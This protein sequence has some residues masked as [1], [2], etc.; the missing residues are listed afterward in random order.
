MWIGNESD[1]V[2]AIFVLS[3][4]FTSKNNYNNN[5]RHVFLARYYITI[6]LSF[7]LL[8]CPL[9]SIAYCIFTFSTAPNLGYYQQY[10][11]LLLLLPRW[12]YLLLLICMYLNCWYQFIHIVI[13][14]KLPY[15]SCHRTWGSATNCVKNFSLS[16]TALQ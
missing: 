5:K 1:R 2:F 8:L 12:H 3:V 13:V 6:F 14:V 11:R 16:S 4:D 10:K 9:F 7:D 15:S